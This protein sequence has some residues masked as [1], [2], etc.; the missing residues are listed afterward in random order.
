MPKPDR[1][2]AQASRGLTNGSS[3]SGKVSFAGQMPTDKMGF[4]SSGREKRDCNGK[5]TALD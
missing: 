4:Y 1:Y 5:A 2:L 3:L